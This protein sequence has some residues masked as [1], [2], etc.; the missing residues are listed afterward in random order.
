VSPL[1]EP[2]PSGPPAP[3][4]AAP[5]PPPIPPPSPPAPVDAGQPDTG[6]LL[7][8][9][10]QLRDE[11]G[12]L[13]E[14][15]NQARTDSQAQVLWDIDRQVAGVRTQLAQNQAAHEEE[16]VVAQRAEAQRHEAVM[17]LFAAQR[18]LAFGDG[19]V[20]DSLDAAEPAL[21]YPAQTALENC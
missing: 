19:R 1:V 4:I 6:A 12:R 7:D 16:S 8:Q 2:P 15:L 13:K 20:L 11:V 17:K 9:V 3:V 10:E 14:Q 5:A 21:P 18:S